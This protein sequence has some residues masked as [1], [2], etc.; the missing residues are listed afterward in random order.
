M[1]E[2]LDVCG[3]GIGRF[4]PKCEKYPN[5]EKD[6]VQKQWDCNRVKYYLIFLDVI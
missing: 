2:E 6:N 4:F 1:A 5:C 3:Q